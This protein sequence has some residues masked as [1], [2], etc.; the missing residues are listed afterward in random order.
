MPNPH[1]PITYSNSD[2]HHNRPM[3]PTSRDMLQLPSSKKHKRSQSGYSI[4][5]DEHMYSKHS[6]YEPP[7]SEA[8]YD[9]FRASRAPIIPSQV[10]HQNV[11][12]H[13][14]P[15]NGSRKL[16]PTTALG[17]RTGSSLR[18]KALTNSKHS[19]AISRGSSKRSTPSQR[20]VGR[21]S[22]SRS[23][24]ASSHWPSSPPVVVR[25]GRLGRRG[26]SFAHLRRSSAATAS[27]ADG[28]VQ[29]TPE[30]RSILSYRDS[31]GSSVL[32]HRPSTVQGSPS[33]RT[34]SRTAASPMV[35]RLRVRKPESPS[36]YIQKEARKVS[37]E[38]EK[39]MEEAFNRASIGSS[40][41]ATGEGA[42]E[43]NTPPTSIS[44]RDSGGSAALATPNNRA[45]M[46]N[47][48]LPPVPNETP[49]TFIHRKLAETRAEFARRLDESG[50]NTEHFV[51]VI[52]HLDR[53]MVPSTNG[54]K[55]TSSAPAKSPEQSVPLHVIPEEAKADEDL[56]ELDGPS[57]RAVTDPVRP[58]MQ[59]RR[60]VTDHTTIR[61]VD[62]S[63]TR[64]APL[65]I[66]KRS[67]ASTSSRAANDTTAVPWPRQTSHQ[68]AQNNPPATR[69]NEEAAAVPVE[70]L[71]KEATVK[72]K[73]SSW[74]RRTPEERDRPQEHQPKPKPSTS[75]L[76]I[77]EA[78]QGLDDRIK[79]DLPR[80]SGPSPDI[81]KHATK[82]STGSSSSEFPMRGCG[83]TV[84]KSEG[85]GARKGFF[86]L[87][88][89][90]QKDDKGKRPMELGGEYS[91][92]HFRFLGSL[93][94]PIPSSFYLHAAARTDRVSLTA[95]NFST[96]S[97]LSSFELGPENGP[98]TS[99]RSGPP[100]FQMN[101]LSR[102]LH[103]KPA[104]KVLCFHV[105]RGK[106]RQDLVR[107]LRDWQRFGVRD[108]N[109]DRAT[110]VINARI[111]K[112]N[113]KYIQLLF[114]AW[115]LEGNV[116]MLDFEGVPSVSFR[117]VSPYQ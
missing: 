41:R 82:Q 57:Y 69:T 5:N 52:E 9:P 107:L 112:N 73:K 25:P 22:V 88:G 55:R 32:S 56:F 15:S 53:L 108:V 59:G 89:K 76:Q 54:A 29:Y 20:S 47:R 40:V 91:P 28:T 17:H 99:A 1:H 80:I 49:N 10:V 12:V 34:V 18:V 42:S 71:E 33:I 109:F 83:T 90:K 103:I 117:N 87:F 70:I 78:W 66:R 31:V 27:T 23:S 58:N 67:G 26:V 94:A 35:P 84:G 38:L 4:L 6:F 74:F 101:W 113:R 102:F 96:S 81:A 62:Q 86:G 98:E 36:K 37:T 60:A 43:Y 79:N 3:A 64:I 106:V 116:F 63:P 48:P 65:N 7:S 8:S 45:T 61:L 2:H 100:E 104:S 93:P 19:S 11:T 39:V 77:P 30:Q 44:N 21:R 72:K 51:E 92:L 111:D 97:I 105:G 75:R 14:G 50:D 24:M 114:A 85:G 46:Q 95:D 68:S 110:N 16:R 13:R 115:S